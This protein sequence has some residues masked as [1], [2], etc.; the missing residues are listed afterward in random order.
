MKEWLKKYWSILA[1]VVFLL[2]LP[3]LI[4]L[5][6]RLESDCSELHAPSAWATFWATYLAAIASFAM[7]F[8]TWLTLKKN[9]EQNDAILQQNKDQLNEMKRQWENEHRPYLE[10]YQLKDNIYTNERR[11]IEFV[12]LG[13]ST[14]TNIKFSIDKAAISQLSDSGKEIVKS[15]G[16]WDIFSLFPRET[17]IFTLHEQ[18]NGNYYIGGR[19]VSKSD[20]YLFVKYINDNHGQIKISGMYNNK[21]HFDSVLCYFNS[22]QTLKDRFN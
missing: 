12:N 19:S 2:V 22:R 21:Y 10:V 7:V 17:R 16:N 5:C 9:K 1:M 14:A 6:Y 4:N 18:K 11:I 8:I 3:L 20:F 15:F 13:L